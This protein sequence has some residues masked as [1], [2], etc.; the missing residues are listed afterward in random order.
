MGVQLSALQATGLD[1]YLGANSC[2][3][4]MEV[5]SVLASS[6]VSTATER[7]GAVLPLPQSRKPQCA[8][9][10]PSESCSEALTA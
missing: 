3:A 9:S 10:L 7:A 8:A 6:A 4:H 1:L 5:D 2:K